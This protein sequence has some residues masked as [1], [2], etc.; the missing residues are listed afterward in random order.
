MDWGKEEIS[1][2]RYS[3]LQ[4]PLLEDEIVS[5]RA[6]VDDPNQN[7]IEPRSE[8]TASTLIDNRSKFYYIF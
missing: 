2:V 8:V 5:A 1:W 6:P 4:I 7:I 3:D